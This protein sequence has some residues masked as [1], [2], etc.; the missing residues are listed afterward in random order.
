MLIRKKCLILQEPFFYG[1]CFFMPVGCCFDVGY[2][3][4]FKMIEIEDKIVSEDLF[5]SFFCCDLS[6][7]HGA[8][9]VEGD[10]GA[11]LEEEEIG[12]IEDYLEAIK[13]YMTPEGI[14]AVEEQGV[15]EVDFEGSY[16]TTLV[17][18]KECA[19]SFRE[20]DNTLCAIERA[21]RAGAIPYNKPVSCH[22]YPIRTIRFSN[23]AIG[24]NYH[25][26]NICHQACINGKARGIKVYQA[27][28][29]PIER[30]FGTEFYGCLEAADALLS[31]EAREEGHD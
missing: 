1:S 21:F 8:C 19:F 25:R 26:W 29:E 20:G 2:C 16:A 17:E 30:V 24:L 27:L 18:G 5:D 6:S 14:A 12:L 13:P 4:K 3:L 31:K 23:G 28:K 10:G 15:F 9:C 11:P 22:L 7:C